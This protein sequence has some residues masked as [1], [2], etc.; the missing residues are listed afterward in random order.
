MSHPEAEPGGLGQGDLVNSLDLVSTCRENGLTSGYIGTVGGHYLG[1]ILLTTVTL[2]PGGGGG[3][4]ILKKIQ[5]TAGKLL[6][7]EM[8]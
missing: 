1:F 8:R 5:R 2:I 4:V 6:Q 3:A 7:L